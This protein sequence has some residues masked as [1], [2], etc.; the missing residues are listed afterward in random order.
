MSTITIR[1]VPITFPYEPY[2]IQRIY[3]EKVIECLQ[4]ETNGVLESPTGT[5]KTLCLLCSSLAWLTAK[6]AQL[7]AQHQTAH[8]IPKLEDT[9]DEFLQLLQEHINSKVG[10]SSNNSGRTFMSVPTIIYASRTHSQL[11]QAMQELKKTSYVHLKATIVGSREQLC[12]HQDVI[13]EENNSM[14]VNIY[15]KYGF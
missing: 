5:G 4:N 7:Q 15:F 14:K 11:S 8:Q 13:K 10:S 6:K 12:I 2:E 3:M 9:D 1:G